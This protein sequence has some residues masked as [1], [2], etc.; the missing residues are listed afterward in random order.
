VGL[1]LTDKGV[2]DVHKRIEV[3]QERLETAVEHEN[4]AACAVSAMDGWVSAAESPAVVRCELTGTRGRGWGG[5]CRSSTRSWPCC[6][7]TCWPAR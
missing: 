6:A 7:R 5:R 2:K 1:K 3:L 4:V